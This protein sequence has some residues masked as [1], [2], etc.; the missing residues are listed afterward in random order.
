M[1]SQLL[2]NRIFKLPTVKVDDVTCAELP[3]PETKI[4]REKPLPKAR[5]LTKWEKFAKEKGIVKKKKS[6]V[7]WDDAVREWVPRYGYKKV[8]AEEEKN[9]IMPYKG[10]KPD[11][12]PRE[13]AIEKKRENVAKNE[14][15]RLRNIARSKKVRL[16]GVGVAPMVNKQNSQASGDLKKAA[17]L[18]HVSTA[19]LG[20]FQDKLSGQMEKTAAK[21]GKGGTG[22]KRKFEPLVN[23]GEREKSLKILEQMSSKKPKIDMAQAVGKAIHQ[24]DTQRSQQKAGKGG[25]K[26]GK[27]G[28][29]KGGGG[30]GKARFSKKGGRASGGKG[31]S[32]GGKRRGKNAKK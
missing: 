24:E 10:D 31:A 7:V 29:K 21:G 3:P 16:P 12:D 20:K 17:D 28:G 13:K 9:W 1:K 8:Q 14:L 4:P 6:R 19:S 26:G 2:L 30:G 27:G 32:A 18:A 15:Q 11:E 25:K 23:A 22:K 5:E